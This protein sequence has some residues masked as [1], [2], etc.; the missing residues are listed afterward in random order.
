MSIFG[1]K[2]PIY[3]CSW[4]NLLGVPQPFFQRHIPT[5]DLIQKHRILFVYM[6]IVRIEIIIAYPTHRHQ[7]IDQ[8]HALFMDLVTWQDFYHA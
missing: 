5:I 3:F 8:I 1:E 4:R 2:T 7:E 6:R